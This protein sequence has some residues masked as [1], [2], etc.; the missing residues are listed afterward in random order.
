MAS[1][2]ERRKFLA[3]LLGGA[4]AW[5]LAARAQ[6]PMPVIGFLSSAF[7]D[8]DAGRLNGFRQGLSETGY[9]EG[10]NVSIEYRWAEEQNDRLPALA[11]DLVRRQVAVIVQ[12]GQVLGALEAK[13]ATK[14][15]PIV[16]VTGGDPVALRLVASLNQPGGNVTGVTTLSVKLEPKKLELLHHVVPT[17]TTIGALVNRTNPNFETQSRDLQ[18]AARALRLKLHILNASSEHDFGAVFTRLL[19]LQAGGLVIAT[20]GFLHSRGDHLGA[21]AIRYAMPAIFHFRPFVAAGGLMSY[22][23]N[24][25]DAY[26]LSGIYAGR[27]L[28]GEKPGD[29]AVQQSTRVELVIN[30]KTAKALG[31]DIPPTLLARADEVIE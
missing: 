16:F 23:G 24:L 25:A 5:P 2:I 13:A 21:L 8:Q 10:R 29:L 26:R 4:G 18:A 3:T 12:A 28:K 22:G 31:L 20:D 9:V 17:T 19:E 7:R 15:I 14:T 1:H 27:I 11:A 6:E 30:L